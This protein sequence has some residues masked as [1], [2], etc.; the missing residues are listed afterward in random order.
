MAVYCGGYVVVIALSW[1]VVHHANV[2]S[3]ALMTS[4]CIGYYWSSCTVVSLAPVCSCFTYC[5]I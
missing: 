1:K 4:L 2:H 5:W 3:S